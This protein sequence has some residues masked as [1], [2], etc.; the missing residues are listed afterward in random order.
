MKR[1]MVQIMAVLLITLFAAGL[2]AAPVESPC[3][4]AVREY[5]A[6][7]MPWPPESVRVDFLS[8]E[9]G[10]VPQSPSLTLRVEPA[11]NLDF[12]GDTV[13]LVKAFRGGSLLRTESVRARIEVLRD[14][15]TAARGM[16]SGTI[17]SESDLRTVRRWVRRIPPNALVSTESAA[18]KRLAVQVV[19]GTEI[20]TPMLKEIPLVRRGKMVKMVFEN[21]PMQI[22]TVGMSEEDG[23]A[24]NII[25]VKN[26][27][28]N[29]TIYAKVLS[30]SIVGVGF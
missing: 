5:I 27:T 26:V 2:E 8:E 23:V 6:A 29:K 14:V 3:R 16:A 25:R 19:A 30:D 20:L 12:V 10:S 15:V 28:S 1:F 13:F 7:N 22:V 18:G 17:L 11:G 9:P 21:G 4:A 24:G